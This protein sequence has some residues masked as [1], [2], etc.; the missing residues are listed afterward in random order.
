MLPAILM[1]AGTL[2]QI[3]S[4]YM[5]NLAKSKQ[6]MENA[7]FY[8][9]QAHLAF[10]S[11]ERQK[12]LAETEYSFKI[13]NMTSQYAGGGVDISGSALQTLSG[14]MLQAVDEVWAIE[15]RGQLEMS[16]ARMRGRNAAE[17]GETLASDSYNI[18]QGATTLLTNYTAS[19][20]FGTDFAGLR[21]PD[22]GPIPKP[23]PSQQ[24]PAAHNT[25]GTYA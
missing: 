21:K 4:Q 10:L 9:E 22:L 14:A 11:K 16:L 19:G 5:S 6:E 15:K 17:M 23:R 7:A 20:G 25:G 24:L 13:G 3:S 12:R 8:E 2:F 1:G 18:T